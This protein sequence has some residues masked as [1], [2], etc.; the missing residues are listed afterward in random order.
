MRKSGGVSSNRTRHHHRYLPLNNYRVA[1]YNQCT[2][3][4]TR[5]EYAGRVP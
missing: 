2:M 1:V 5:V 3:P 4:F